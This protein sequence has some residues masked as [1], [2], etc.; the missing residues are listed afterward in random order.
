M[1][2]Y[3]IFITIIY[4]EYSFYLFSS[5][6]ILY[7]LVTNFMS[8]IYKIC[9]KK[10]QYSL[11]SLFLLAYFKLILSLSMNNY[12]LVFIFIKKLLFHNLVYLIV[13]SHNFWSLVYLLIKFLFL[14]P[15]LTRL[16]LKYYL[17]W[18]DYDLFVTLLFLKFWIGQVIVQIR[19]IIL[20]SD[21]V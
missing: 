19:V 14:L 4:N 7:L 10:F 3:Y 21:F 12:V 16:I 17:F 9:M 8:T 5:I 1:E 15:Q 18:S 13:W 11:F 2:R 20:V 6:F